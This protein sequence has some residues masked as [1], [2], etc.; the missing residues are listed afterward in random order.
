MGEVELFYNNAISRYN[1]LQ[2]QM[3]KISLLHGLTYQI[4]YTWGKDLTDADA[5]WGGAAPGASGGITQNDPTCIRCEYARATYNVSQRFAANFAYHLPSRWGAVPGVFSNG[6]Q[7]LGIYNAQSGFPFSVVGPYGTYQ[8]GYDTFNGVGARPN[9][10]RTAPRDPEHRKQFFS[11]DVIENTQNYFGIPT[12]T[13]TVNGLGTV[14]TAPGT[15]GRNPTPARLVELRLLCDQADANQR[16]AQHGIPRGILQYL[17][18]PHDCHA[19]REHQQSRWQ[20]TWL[21]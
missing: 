19:Q 12:T 10:I 2:V 3:R 17:Q 13:S 5:I 16:M 4:N 20:H 9:F 18:S 21:E 7:A 8:Y 1:A 15:L 14:Q 6:W 11:D